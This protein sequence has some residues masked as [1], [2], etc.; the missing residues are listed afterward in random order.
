MHPN[1]QL[2]GLGSTGIE[3]GKGLISKDDDDGSSELSSAWLRGLED[4]DVKDEFVDAP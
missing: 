2:S 4:T 1:I 3:Y